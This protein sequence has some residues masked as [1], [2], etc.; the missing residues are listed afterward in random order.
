MFICKYCG[1]EVGNNGCLVLHEKRCI[2]NPNRIISKSQAYKEDKDSRRDE[3]GK[4]KI[5]GHKHSE[6]TKN[7]LSEIRKK[8]LLEHKDEHVWRRDSKFLSEPCENLKQYLRQKNISF[9]EEY[10]P[11]DDVN[12]CLDIAW[13]DEKIA[14]EINGSQHYD[15]NGNLNKSTL[16]KQKFFEDHG[17]KIIQI[18]YKWCYGVLDINK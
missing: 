16:D 15:T 11:F 5:H 18:Y 1:K 13:P 2:K 6:E 17:W 7:K 9:V 4:I 10:E 12:Y 3:N 8:W 14:I